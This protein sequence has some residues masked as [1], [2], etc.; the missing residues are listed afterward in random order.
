[1]CVCLVNLTIDIILTSELSINICVNKYLCACVNFFLFLV[2]GAIHSS[3][4]RLLYNEC[5]LLN[6]CK[7]GEAKITC[8]YNLP[9]KCK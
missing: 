4:G 2:D 6:G 5:E 8:G 7:K 1:M 9:A 3:A